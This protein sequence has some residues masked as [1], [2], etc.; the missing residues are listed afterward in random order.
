M[1]LGKVFAVMT[2]L[3]LAGG[4]VSRAYLPLWI[5]VPFFVAWMLVGLGCAFQGS[6]K[7][8]K[9]SEV[10]PEPYEGGPY[11]RHPKWTRE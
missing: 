8:E 10:E 5:K 2:V 4:C 9:T 6:V 7:A 11:N 1:T 3:M